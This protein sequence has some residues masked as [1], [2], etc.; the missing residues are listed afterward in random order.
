MDPLPDPFADLARLQLPEQ[1]VAP[2]AQGA[3][4]RAGAGRRFLKGPVPWPWLERAACLPGRALHVGLALWHLVGLGRKREV[5][6]T[7][8]VLASMGVDRHAAR[9]G[10]T[11]LETAGLVTMIRHP[12]RRP[13]VTVLD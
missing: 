3:R 11:A 1:K 13:R 8:S 9:R 10:L 7:G 12:G 2:S 4:P 6:L 5:V